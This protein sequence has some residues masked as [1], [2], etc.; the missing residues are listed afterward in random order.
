MV[1][2]QVCASRATP[3]TILI[4][5]R[6][7][8]VLARSAISTSFLCAL[9]VR[10]TI[11]TNIGY[12]VLRTTSAHQSKMLEYTW[13]F[14]SIN[15]HRPSTPYPQSTLAVCFVFL[16]CRAIRPIALLLPYSAMQ[17][18]HFANALHNQTLIIHTLFFGRTQSGV[19]D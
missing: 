19:R 18:S 6:H 14:F 9:Y 12:F 2:C 10:A 7:D 16:Q 11:I 17:S 15:F 4:T 1:L 3:P 13:F 5:N 8:H